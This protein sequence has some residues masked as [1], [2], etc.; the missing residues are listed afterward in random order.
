MCIACLR[1]CLVVIAAMAG[2]LR[3]AAPA[4]AE[5]L[6]LRK[7]LPLPPF[8]EDAE[9]Q[10]AFD[11]LQLSSGEWLKGEIEQMISDTLYFDSD[12][13]DSVDFDWEDVRTLVSKNVISLRLVSQEVIIGRIELRAGL[14]RIH[15]SEGVREFS[16]GEILQIIPGQPTERNYWSGG[17]SLG[18]S[19]RSGNTNQVD[20]TLRANLMRQTV[21]TR[22]ETSYTGEVST[23]D[24][25][26]TTNSHRVPSQF[27]VYLTPRFYL[28]TPSFEYYTDEFQNIDARL[29]AGLGL[30]YEVFENSWF[31][32]EV[33]TGVSYQGT[34]YESVEAGTDRSDNDAV[35]VF[36]TGIEFDL[37]RG[38]EWEN[39]YQ[40]HAVVTDPD[41]TSHHAESILS[42][43]VWKPIDFELALI[44]DRIE[45]PVPDSNGNRPKSNDLRLTAGFGIDF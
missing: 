29:T 1:R 33:G 37:P 6:P 30:G 14:A 19:T 38:L 25:D 15:T 16:P 40:L 12:E 24:D 26:L 43:D 13:F 34:L 8:E 11:W 35:L 17:T 28:T 7:D 10:L 36:S 22:W 21:L 18:L 5:G 42:F 3:F 20:L 45:K 27:D 23:V 31:F 2:C 4:F 39:D 32:W 44:F 41:K 9:R